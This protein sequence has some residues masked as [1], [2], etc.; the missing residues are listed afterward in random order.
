MAARILIIVGL[1]ALSIGLIAGAGSQAVERRVRGVLPYRG[2]SP[3]LVLLAAVPVTILALVLVSVP[4]ALLGVT[5]DGPLAAL[6]SVSVQA[7]IYIGLVRLLVV[8][9]GA[10]DWGA[11]GLK[12]FDRGAVAEMVG[13]A[14]W[15]F[16]VVIVTGIVASILF[17]LVPVEPVS[18]LP[19]TGTAAGFALSLLAGVV[20][21]PFGE[22]ILFRGFATT[23]WVRGPTERGAGLILAALVFAFAHVV[24]ISGVTAGDALQQAFVGVRAGSRSRSRWAGCSCGAGRSGPR[25]GCTP[26]STDPARHRRDRQP[27]QLIRPRPVSRGAHP[28]EWRMRARR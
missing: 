3:Y 13:G 4:F 26:R 16:P 10:L 22:E 7:A 9:S 14:L 27:A 2:P 18:P 21:A 25:S 23:A 20:V 15:A 24:T 6:L 11:M 1:V 19:P 8:D 17:T 28:I 5:L 12:R